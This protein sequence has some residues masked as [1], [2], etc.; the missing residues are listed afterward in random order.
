MAII[1][2]IYARFGALLAL[3]YQSLS[4]R[5]LLLLSAFY[6]Y[7]DREG[8]ACPRSHTAQGD[9]QVGAAAPESMQDRPAPKPGLCALTGERDTG[10][11]QLAWVAGERV[12]KH[13]DN[14]FCFPN[15]TAQL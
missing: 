15:P 6:G 11:I 14:L 2:V 10:I 5:Y 8:Y 7:R 12:S 3:S 13:T 1:F 9:T 4:G